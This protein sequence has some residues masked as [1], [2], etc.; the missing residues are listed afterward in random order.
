MTKQRKLKYLLII[1]AFII[2]CFVS[3][4]NPEYAE[5]IAQAFLL[6]LGII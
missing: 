3:I 4:F 6:I 5:N 1:G 2:I